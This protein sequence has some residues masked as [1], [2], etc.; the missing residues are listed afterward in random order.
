MATSPDEPLVS[1]DRCSPGV[2][3]RGIVERIIYILYRSIYSIQ[4]V[5]NIIPIYHVDKYVLYI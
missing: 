5:Y 3:H 1:C 2:Q 4:R